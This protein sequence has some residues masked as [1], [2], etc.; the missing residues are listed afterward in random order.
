MG[1]FLPAKRILLV[2]DDSDLLQMLSLALSSNG[3]EVDCCH[4]GEQALERLKEGEH[5][6]VLLDIM[7]PGTDGY[8]ICHQMR[9]TSRAP[10]LM[11]TARDEVQDKVIGLEVGAD[12]YVTKPFNTLELIARIKA[13]IRRHQ[14][15]E[16]ESGHRVVGD[17][18]L[19]PDRRCLHVKGKAIALTKKEFALLELL[20]RN[21]GKAV[22]RRRMLD[23]VWHGNRYKNERSVDVCVRRLRTKIEDDPKRPKYLL[24]VWGMGYRVHR[25]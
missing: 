8:Q 7:M 17:L 14:W 22:S 15:P 21:A 18:E 9:K 16:L 25:P 1:G 19:D 4:D 2:D 6:C 11:L 3:F 20:M 13:A 12:D 5:D 24:T 23:E 10:I